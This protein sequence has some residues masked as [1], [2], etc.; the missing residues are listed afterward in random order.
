MDVGAQFLITSQTLSDADPLARHSFLPV[1]QLAKKGYEAYSD[2]QKNT[3]SSSQSN[4]NNRRSSFF[5]S[6]R[7]CGPSPF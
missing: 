1:S 7:C 3:N 6:R 4:D 5:A 2:S